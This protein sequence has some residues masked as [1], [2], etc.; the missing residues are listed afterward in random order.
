MKKALTFLGIT[1]SLLLTACG[2]ELPNSEQETA[3]N[4]TEELDEA[5]QLDESDDDTLIVALTNS[6]NGFDPINTPG[7]TFIHRF[8]YDTLLVMPEAD[9][10][11]EALATSFETE[12]NETFT[13]TLNPDAYWTDG[14]PITAEDVAFSLNAIVHPDYQSN[15]NAHL[16]ILE[17]T[18]HAGRLLEEYDELPGV[19]VID[20]YTLSFRTKHPV[21]LDLAKHAVG[22][23][24]Y[25]APSHIFGELDPAEATTSEHSTQPTVTSGP[26]K[27]VEYDEDNYVHLEANE[28]YYRGSPEIETIYSR[29]LNSSLLTTEFQ[30][31]NLHMTA[32]GGIA[33]VPHEDIPLLEEIDGLVIEENPSL[34]VQ[35]LLVNH[36]V[37]DDPEVRLALT[38]AIDRELLL[39]NLIDGRGEI[40][41]GPYTSIHPYQRDD[42][43][44]HAF[45]PDLAR[46]LLEQA[47]FDFDRE[48]E[49]VVPT[50]NSIREQAG[51]LIYQWFNDIGLNVTLVN[52]DFP[53]WLEQANSG[54]YDFGLMAWSNSIDPDPSTNFTGEN[55][56]NIDDPI[57][58]ELLQ[59]GLQGTSFEERYET[60]ATFQEYIHENAVLV[61]LYTE[62][63]YSIQVEE[64]D[65]GV[66][67]YSGGTFSHIH[68]WSLDSI[69]ENN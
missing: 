40:V 55:T 38:H 53:T 50:G 58:D 11:E 60:Y 29:V 63:Q 61:P 5:L 57:I 13:V 25:I 9:E 24:V 18:D 34:I 28:D 31:G 47:D 26:Y 30:A 54:D 43:D 1:A 67:A 3:T 59:E 23:Q 15:L 36:E 48:Y 2:E 66:E 56:S 33:V 7:M 37:F 20:E 22:Y 46:E 4:E 35:Y 8:I 27:F 62:S 12:D 52:I 45:D 44:P 32:G 14:E 10:Y 68:E 19:E 6:P 39:N 21:D 42:L 49:F 51:D 41:N 69:D 16:S 65:G 17:G 64:L